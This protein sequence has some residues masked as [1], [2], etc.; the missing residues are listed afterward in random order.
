MLYLDDIVIFSD[1]ADEHISHLRQFFELIRASG[2]KINPK[3]IQPLREKIK[4]LGHI[5]KNG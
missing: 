3:K 5:V 4:I 2:L 1:S